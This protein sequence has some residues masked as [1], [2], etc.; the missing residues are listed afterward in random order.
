MASFDVVWQADLRLCVDADLVAVETFRR[1]LFENDGVELPTER[2]ETAF[3]VAPDGSLKQDY[4]LYAEPAIIG[5]PARLLRP[6]RPAGFLLAFTL[7]DRLVD[8]ILHVNGES[9]WQFTKKLNAIKLRVAADTLTE[10]AEFAATIA[11]ATRSAWWNTYCALVGVRN[12]IAHQGGV[13]VA[14]GGALEVTGRDGVRYVLTTGEQAAYARLVAVSAKLCTGAIRPSSRIR[15]VVDNDLTD[16]VTFHG[17]ASLIK[18]KPVL[19]RVTFEHPA[20]RCSVPIGAMRSRVEQS[21][22]PVAMELHVTTSAAAY[23]FPSDVTTC[24]EMKIDDDD[25]ML[26]AFRI[27]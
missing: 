25:P 15:T 4:F 8:Q 20:S 17:I 10:P 16:L 7:H 3:R 19:V 18:A 6:L 9:G 13:V 12:A 5:N 23:R 27:T 24:D 1:H 2:H 26:A 21:W 11:G 22:G 14:S